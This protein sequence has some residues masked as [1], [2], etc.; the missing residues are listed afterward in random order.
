MTT[1]SLGHRKVPP[2]EDSLLLAGAICLD[3]LEGPGVEHQGFSLLTPNGP[4]KWSRQMFELTP[5]LHAVLTIQ[6]IGLM[7]GA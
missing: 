7:L 1:D 6:H 4:A 5:T 3:A 2:A